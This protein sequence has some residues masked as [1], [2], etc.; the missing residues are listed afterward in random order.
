[1]GG[2]GTIII[3][4]LC[5]GLV[6]VTLC[7]FKTDVLIAHCAGCPATERQTHMVVTCM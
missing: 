1:M 7:I 4:G 5:R 3:T 2:G 6:Q